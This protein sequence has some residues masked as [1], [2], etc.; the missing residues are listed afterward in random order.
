[1]E[2][3]S[4]VQKFELM[5]QYTVIIRKKIKKSGMPTRVSQNLKQTIIKQQLEF[6]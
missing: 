4:Q 1:M 6:A 2:V 5:L 3:Q